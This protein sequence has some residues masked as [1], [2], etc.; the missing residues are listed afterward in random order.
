MKLLYGEQ[1]DKD[2]RH[3]IYAVVLAR[4]VFGFKHSINTPLLE[5][6]IDEVEGNAD[7]YQDLRWSLGRWDA[8]GDAKYYVIVGAVNED[9]GWVEWVDPGDGTEPPPVL[10]PKQYQAVTFAV[11]ADKARLK[12]LSEKT[13][14]ADEKDE[15]LG[16]MM[17]RS[18]ET[19]IAR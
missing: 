1:A 3:H 18:V 16:L 7:F 19:R 13:M 9:I 12:V 2:G 14:T 17:Q 6:E 15:A 11:D 8:G 5:M 4:A 10:E